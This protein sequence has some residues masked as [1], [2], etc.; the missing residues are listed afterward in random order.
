MC[1]ECN[2][3]SFFIEHNDYY[4]LIMLILIQMCE[5]IDTSSMQIIQ[6]SHLLTTYTY[7]ILTQWLKFA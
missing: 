2:I 1:T 4:K 6:V 7:W 3:A 5:Y